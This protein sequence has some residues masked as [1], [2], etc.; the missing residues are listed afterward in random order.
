ME[1]KDSYG[2]FL[3]DFFKT[4]F[5]ETNPLKIYTLGN[6]YLL[7]TAFH[8]KPSFL[9]TRITVEYIFHVSYISVKL[10]PDYFY[11]LGDFQQ[12]EG[13]DLKI[14]FGDV[15]EL[16][17]YLP[18]KYLATI[19]DLHRD[20]REKPAPHRWPEANFWLQ[21]QRIK[22]S[23]P[24]KKFTS[25]SPLKIA[26]LA[27]QI[28]SHDARATAELRQ[29]TSIQSNPR[30][31]PLYCEKIT[32]SG[33]LIKARKNNIVAFSQAD[34]TSIV[35]E[36]P[37]PTVPINPATEISAATMADILKKFTTANP[38]KLKALR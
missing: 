6:T 13:V 37:Q 8:G 28:N 22:I 23:D 2:N 29:K 19:T 17:D 30:L 26:Y 10:K 35:V 14:N 9:D 36:E 4:T 12:N 27:D 21:I 11:F 18:H 24:L 7:D 32:F 33:N 3:T 31:L 34:T 20:Q 1:A 5:T 15:V 38:L 16:K 25:S